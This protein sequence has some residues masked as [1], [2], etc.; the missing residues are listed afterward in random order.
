MAVIIHDE[1]RD[2]LMRRRPVVALESA[3]ITA[4]LP[5]E[6]VKLPPRLRIDGWRADEPVNLELARAMERA[7]RAGGAVPA[8]VAVIDGDLRIGLDADILERLARD[9]HAAKAGITDLAGMLATP[10]NRRGGA[11]VNAGTT[12]SATLAACRLTHSPLKPESRSHLPDSTAGIR[13]FATGGIGGVHRGW[14][15][16][17]DV[18][19]D[20]RA[21]ASTPVCVVCSGAKAILDLPATLEA[22]EALNVPVIGHRT[23]AF[24]QFQSL[25]TSDLPLRLCV[26]DA[27][28]AAAICRAQWDA[29]GL[30]AGVIL[31]NPAP[32]EFAVDARELSRAIESA[33]RTAKEHRISGPKRTPFLL[34][35]I[36]RLTHNR[37]LEANLALLVD[38][39]RLAAQVAIALVKSG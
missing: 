39:A 5:H 35:E 11:S 15:A 32:G 16:M 38:N 9:Q 6:P 10:D 22:L 34:G 14:Q 31:A 19:A 3:V 18:S 28:A 20:L 8:T 7:V 29:L 25:G 27:A 13:V 24:P 21:V 23:S 26:D 37:S 33:E 36:S 30:T 4:G 1:V 12:V 2:A 17:P